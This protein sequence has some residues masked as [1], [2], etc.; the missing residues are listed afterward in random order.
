MC[1]VFLFKEN[2]FHCRPPVSLNSV[3]TGLS[4]KRTYKQKNIQNSSVYAW[5]LLNENISQHKP[6]EGV[7]EDESEFSR[8]PDLHL[9]L[10]G[11]LMRV[12]SCQRD[13]NLKTSNQVWRFIESLFKISSSVQM[14]LFESRAGAGVWKL[15]CVWLL[16]QNEPKICL[17]AKL[18]SELSEGLVLCVNNTIYI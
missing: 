11:F 17:T 2:H 5:V 3:C 10:N 4:S 13:E 9:S 8:V 6:G 1:D 7:V 15:W 14:F 18:R 12:A 16:A